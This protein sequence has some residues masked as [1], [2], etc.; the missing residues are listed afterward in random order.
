M[1]RA[2]SSSSSSPP[3]AA[4]L[5]ALLPGFRS[6]IGWPGPRPT[7]SLITRGRPIVVFGDL[8]LTPDRPRS[9]RAALEFIGRLNATNAAA[10]ICLGDLFE[11][12]F[13][14][15]QLRGPE[16]EIVDALVQLRRRGVP[17]CLIPGNR[18]FMA[19]SCLERRG[20]PVWRDWLHLELDHHP[21]RVSI[22]H[23]DAL[24]HHDNFYLMFRRLMHSAFVRT[25]AAFAPAP[26]LLG[27]AR[28]LR[29]D[30]QL[31]HR[32]RAEKARRAAAAGQP[33]R[34]PV[35]RERRVPREVAAGVFALPDAPSLLVCGHYHNP[36][37]EAWPPDHQL[38]TVGDW[39]DTGGLVSLIWTP[40]DVELRHSSVWP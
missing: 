18:D 30:S 27:I 13:G 28:Y 20:L 19:G 38:V 15:P 37:I 29:W 40:R 10:A 3:P 6:R 1:E 32:H 33:V 4:H 36:G 11:A 12:Y 21:R 9:W 16:G 23:G 35:R 25:A 22:T 8:H 24:M 7:L 39:N 34:G 26:V 14:E 5:P 31:R 17:V 2:S